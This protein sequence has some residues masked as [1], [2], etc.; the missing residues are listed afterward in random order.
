VTK[1][2]MSYL[3][4]LVVGAQF[5]TNGRTI[6]ETDIVMFAGLSGDYSPMHT[7]EEWSRQN[8]PFG[9]RVAH[10]MLIASISYGLRVDVLDLLDVVGWM[11]VTRRFVAPVRAGDTI[12]S[13][14]TLR[15]IRPSSSRPTTGVVVADIEV[16]NQDGTVV[17]AGHDVW[18]VNSRGAQ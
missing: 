18:L 16:T 12:T 10:G 6:T 5:T 14:W 3:E 15:E 13:H 2:N 9:T 8:H 1:T 17:Q 4:D 7:D 11:E